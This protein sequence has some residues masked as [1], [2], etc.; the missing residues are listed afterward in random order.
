MLHC[1]ETVQRDHMTC[2]DP[3]ERWADV[4]L[5]DAIQAQTEALPHLQGGTNFPPYIVELME[6]A[7][8]PEVAMATGGVAVQTAH[9][10]TLELWDLF[11]DQVQH[12]DVQQERLRDEVR[13]RC[14]LA[15][16]VVV[17][18]GALD[19]YHQRLGVLEAELHSRARAE[20]RRAERSVSWA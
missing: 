12:I 10:F 2:R 13:Q 5:N 16:W 20:E 7:S 15:Q 6:R 1:Q 14:L 11:R 4:R 9:L 3:T 8:G 17:L 18:E 19:G